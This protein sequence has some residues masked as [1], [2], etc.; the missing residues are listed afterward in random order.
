LLPAAEYGSLAGPH[1]LLI[2]R[3]RKHCG[4]RVHL[5]PLARM[6]LQS[7][8]WEVLS[9]YLSAPLH[10]AGMQRRTLPRSLVG[11]GVIPAP[12]ESK[13]KNSRV[14]S[15]P[16]LPPG[17]KCSHS[18]PNRTNSGQQKRKKA[19]I[20]SY[21]A[22]PLSNQRAPSQSVVRIGHGAFRCSSPPPASR[23]G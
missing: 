18:S 8:C 3:M 6:P 14:Q 7:A 15:I 19:A 1:L 16:F 13:R 21:P 12:Q 20:L 17:G 22:S 11:R 5:R 2:P 23:R 10:A 9:A 4:V